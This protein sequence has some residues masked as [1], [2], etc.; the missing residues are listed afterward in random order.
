MNTQ[1]PLAHRGVAPGWTLAAVLAVALVAPQVATAADPEARRLPGYVDGS[2]FGELAGEDSEIVEVTIGPTLL[3]AL[4]RA[5]SDDPEAG[6]LI[7]NIQS[8][9]AYI[10]KLDNDARRTERAEKAIGDIE[11]RLTRGGWE[12]IARVREKESKVGVFVH[13]DEKIVDGLVVMV[14]NRDE[15]DDREVVFANIA[16]NIDLARIGELQDR[17]HVPGLDEVE[18]TANPTGAGKAGEKGGTATPHKGK[19][20]AKESDE[21]AP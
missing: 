4:S 14:L 3:K 1:P 5:V 21:D 10:V 9:N 11:A 2:V 12:R 6:E 17:L 20:P 19:H 13:N 8:V 15:G 7:R 16:G 18:G